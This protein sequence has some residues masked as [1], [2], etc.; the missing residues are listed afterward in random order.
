MA[1]NPQTKANRHTNKGKQTY[2]Q[3]HTVSIPKVALLYCEYSPSLPLN[4]RKRPDEH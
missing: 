3:T 2:K 1:I 4:I